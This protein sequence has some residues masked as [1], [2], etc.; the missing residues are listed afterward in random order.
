MV[1]KKSLLFYDEKTK[2]KV[3]GY[4]LNPIESF[5]CFLKNFIRKRT[6]QTFSRMIELI[7]EGKDA[8]KKT[9]N[10]PKFW[11]RFWQAVNIYYNNIPYAYVIKFLYGARTVEIKEDRRI[12]NTTL[13]N[14]N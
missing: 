7:K 10:N 12:Y 13:E 8:F 11:H 4:L 5:W 9:K 1:F 6:N 3:K 14:K 2:Q